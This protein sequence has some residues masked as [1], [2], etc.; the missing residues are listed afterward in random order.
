MRIAVVNET[1]AADKNAAIMAALSNRGHEVVNIGMTVSGAQPEL[2]YIHT[3]FISALL[4]NCGAVDLVVGGCGTGMGYMNS[5][6]QYPNV[7]CGLI[8][9]S[10]DAWLF[11][12][13]NGGNCVSLPLNYEYGWAGDVNLQFV[14]DKLFSVEFGC[15]YPEARKQSQNWSRN[16]LKEVSRT[17]HKSF[18]EIVRQLPDDVVGAIKYPGLL[19]FIN[20]EK[21]HDA[22]L[23]AAIKARLA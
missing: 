12:Q 7:F 3:G 8:K 21:L 4:L 13:I 9:N 20:L 1:S 11:A 18:A 22:D 10:L 16:L 14:F 2:T 23:R 19:D 15:G 5:A 6:L 17:A